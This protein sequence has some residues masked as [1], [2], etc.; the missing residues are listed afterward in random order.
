[1]A[2]AKGLTLIFSSCQKKKKKL[3]TSGQF[4]FL[5]FIEPW[6]KPGSAGSFQGAGSPENT[7][8]TIRKGH[9]LFLMKLWKSAAY[10]TA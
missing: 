7:D 8:V 2:S 10:L 3:Y 9:G 4:P 6:R 1:M 5:S